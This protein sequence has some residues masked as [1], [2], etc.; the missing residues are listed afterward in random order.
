MLPRAEVWAK[1]PCHY[2]AWRPIEGR[3][4][5]MMR[6]C[7]DIGEALGLVLTLELMVQNGF[8]CFPFA[9]PSFSVFFSLPLELTVICERK[10]V[11]NLK[12]KTQGGEWRKLMCV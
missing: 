6:L 11:F 1:E 5:S 7:C 2:F 10:C 8:L 12:V 9:F 3:I 4:K